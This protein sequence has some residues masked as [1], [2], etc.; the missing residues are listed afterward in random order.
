VKNIYC[1][2]FGHEFVVSKQVTHHVK[3]YK[4]KQCHFQ[5]TTDGRGKLTPL[6]PKYKEIN[7]ILESIYLKRSLKRQK[8]LILDSEVHSNL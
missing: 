1:S 7:A 3:E 6:T 8:R 4:C 5:M 2:I